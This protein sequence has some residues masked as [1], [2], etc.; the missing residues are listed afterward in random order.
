GRPESIA[1]DGFVPGNIPSAAEH[2]RDRGRHAAPNVPRD[3]AVRGSLRRPRPDRKGSRYRVRHT[4]TIRLMK[5]R[6][7]V[8]FKASVLDPQGQ[9]IRGALN[10]LGHTS[11]GEVRQGKF[12]EIEITPGA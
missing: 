2:G 8:S 4:L 6:V 3:D 5:A 11:I 7:Y 10:G 9:A 12:F 1:A